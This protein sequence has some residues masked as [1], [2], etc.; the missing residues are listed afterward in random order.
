MFEKDKLKENTIFIIVLIGI[1]LVLT[2]IDIFIN[3]KDNIF[4][5]LTDDK[6]NINQLVINEIMT[7]NKGAYVDFN[8]NAYDWI[9]LYNGY[10]EDINLFN[11]TLSD[12][13]SGKTKW[14]FPNVIIKSKEYL[15]VYL[16]GTN[17]EGMYANFSLKK[18]GG[19]LVTF[20]LH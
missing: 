2:I 8:G 12:E 14:I 9:E 3:N 19:E 4:T 13:E 20:L 5:S 1:I 6:I 11:Y 7:S 15:I 16:S 17:E 18:E 10:D